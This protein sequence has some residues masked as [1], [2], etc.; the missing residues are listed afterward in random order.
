MLPVTQEAQVMR[1]MPETF[2]IGFDFLEVNK[3]IKCIAI[4]QQRDPK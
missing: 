4:F 2:Q 1:C 3:G